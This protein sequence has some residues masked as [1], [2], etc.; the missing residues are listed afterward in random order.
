MNVRIVSIAAVTILSLGVAAGRQA[1]AQSPA[2]P[3]D[4]PETEFA[5]LDRLLH[6]KP[7][8]PADQRSKVLIPQLE[9]FLVQGQALEADYPKAANLYV[10]RLGMLRAAGMLFSEKKDDASRQRMLDVARSVVDNPAPLKAKVYPHR[11]LTAEK[12]QPRGAVA[13]VPGADAIIREFVKK[14]DKTDA[15]AQALMDGCRLARQIK[16]EALAGEFLATLESAHADDPAAFRFLADI[17]R[18]PVFRAALMTLDGKPLKLPEALA[19]KVVVVD[20]WATWCPPC[21]DSQPRMRKLYSKYHKTQNV[22]FV[23]VSL[24]KPGKAEDLKEYVKDAGLPWVH[25]YSGLYQSDPTVRL[26][27]IEAIPSVWVIGRDGR[28]FATN[29]AEGQPK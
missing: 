28:V 23:G 6:V 15:A 20:F 21:V 11:I 29:V 18:G 7:S 14:Y 8:L 9:Q 13:P 4:V 19:G 27:G 10:L 2:G 26:C 22:E 17:G 24:D 1:R 16:N 12:I 5:N 3:G 25:T